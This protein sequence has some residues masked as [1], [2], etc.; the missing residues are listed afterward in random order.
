M[1]GW[2]AYTG[3]TLVA[4]SALLTAL[5]Y[6]QEA[7]VLESIGLAFGVIGIRAKMERDSG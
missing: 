1:T 2:K 6:E 7:R 3:A 4:V 5:G